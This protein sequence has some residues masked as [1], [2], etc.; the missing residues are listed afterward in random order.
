M[1]SVIETNYYNNCFLHCCRLV[2]R[3]INIYCIQYMYYH[4]NG[5]LT[6]RALDRFKFK[7]VFKRRK[8]EEKHTH[9]GLFYYFQFQYS[10]QIC[11]KSHVETILSL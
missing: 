9:F 8:N 1:H 5:V 2:W 11:H 10:M 3:S 6:L 7:S 4:Y